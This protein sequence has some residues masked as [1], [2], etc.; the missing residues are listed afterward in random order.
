MYNQNSSIAMPPFDP[1]EIKIA[2][3]L[4]QFRRVTRDMPSMA[5]IHRAIP[6]AR[7]IISEIKLPKPTRSDESCCWGQSNFNEETK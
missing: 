6:F 2:T 4:C 7:S 1:L 3:R 5:E